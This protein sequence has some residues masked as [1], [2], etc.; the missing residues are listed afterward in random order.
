MPEMT[1]IRT[2]VLE[3]NELYYFNIYDIVGDG[4]GAGYVRLFMG[5]TDISDSGRMIFESDGMFRSGTDHTFFAAF[6]P[7]VLLPPS[8]E[9][10]YLTLVMKT[11][12]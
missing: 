9:Y 11:D 1:V 4:I 5:T 3:K 7:A 10:M 6:P 2:I 8:D 12:L